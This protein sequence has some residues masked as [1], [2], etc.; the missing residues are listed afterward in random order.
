MPEILSIHE[1]ALVN[2]LGH[3]AGTLIFGIFAILLLRDRAGAR[4]RGSRL[5]FTAAGLA[6]LWN[7]SSLLVIATRDLTG[8]TSE[9]LVA[10]STSALSLLPPVLL[11]LSL[12]D[13]FVWIRRTG[14][15]LAA[16]TVALHASEV[17]SNAPEHHLLALR[18]TTAGFSALTILG[19]AGLLRSGS[20]RRP[21]TSRL[22]GTMSLFLFSIS[23]V[24]FGAAEAQSWLS[25]ALVHHAGIPL[26]LFVL[27][28][29]H[30]FLLLDAFTRVL[31]N[32]L[33]AALFVAGMV[34]I[35][36]RGALLGWAQGRP[37]REG[38]LMVAGAGLLL[39]FPVLRGWL[40][41]A[42]AG[43]LFRRAPVEALLDAI[44]PLEDD[45]AT[46][47]EHT[48]QAI[49]RYLDAGLIEAEGRLIDG[50]ITLPAPTSD[51][52]A[53]D[54]E[55][56]DAL[57]VEAILPLRDS[58]GSSRLLLFGRRRG[59]RR[60]LSEDIAAM[61]RIQAEVTYRMDRLH[62]A[63]M[64][65]LVTQAE[66]RAL[67]SQI[68]PHFLFNAFNTLYGIIPREAAGARRTVLN[69]ADIFR[70]FLHS[71]RTF[72]PL[73]QEMQIV[74]AYL[75]IE[76]LRLGDKLRVDL[77]ISP[78]AAV[79]PIPILTVEPLVEN[80][81]KHGISRRRDGGT[82]SVEA[83]IED[84]SLRIAVRDSGG[85]F[86]A[87]P[88]EGA[89]VGLENVIRRLQL[90]YGADAGLDIDSSAEGTTVQFRVPARQQ[91]PVAQ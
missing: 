44:R 22:V 40:L 85:G 43:R 4:L 55:R 59:G 24:H 83:G 23:F 15:A 2:T 56:L 67:Q 46:Y 39:L 86:S 14:Y 10:L 91:E 57:G 60:Y 25:E 84:G 8:G 41:H 62:E 72:I 1:P 73:E 21:L 42:L 28:Q 5:T 48:A 71:D 35:A 53:P 54:R 27:L 32:A 26:A 82:V 37:F 19:A 29:D 52:A 33:F 76:Q 45:P 78:E 90:C 20:D 70:Y 36:D 34:A 66:L 88:G 30:R 49:A 11:H 89:G 69:L 81:V 9:L 63:E 13:R 87:S 6:L 18:I 47:A 50:E 79:L 77:R 17:L 74:Q 12:G 75:E 16:V 38:A 61:T 31:A 3:S 80:A 68:H 7:F 65:R 64:R 51:L 58:A